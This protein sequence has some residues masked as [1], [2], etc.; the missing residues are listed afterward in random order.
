[1]LNNTWAQRLAKAVLK[2]V[3]RRCT[4]AAVLAFVLHRHIARNKLSGDEEKPHEHIIILSYER[5]T[6]DVEE[7]L[8]IKGFCYFTIDDQFATFLYTLFE[9]GSI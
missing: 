5:W 8:K 1:V 3:L 4:L 2:A 7:L 6:Q 9:Q